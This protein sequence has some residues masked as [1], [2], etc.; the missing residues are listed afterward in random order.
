MQLLIVQSLLLAIPLIFAVLVALRPASHAKVIATVGALG[1]TVVALPLLTWFE[2]DK[3]AEV[4]GAGSFMWMPELGLQVSVGVDSVSVLLIAL[5]ALLGPICVVASYSAIT[6][7]LRTYYAWLL[8]LQA[9]MVGVFMARDLVLFYI[10]FEFTLIPMYVLISLFGSTNR[11]K[12]ATRFFLY[13]FTGSIIALAGLMYVVWFNAY[14]LAPD[15]VDGAGAWTFDIGVL[16]ESAAYM[17]ATE[18]GWVLLA[19]LAGFAVKVPL[20]PVHTWLPL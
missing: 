2:W 5:T 14:G 7:R 12:A 10:C 18:Q 17:S 16:T 4:Q 9:A 13:T 11:K 15:R 19:L 20:F 1:Q 3:A 8:I 6:E